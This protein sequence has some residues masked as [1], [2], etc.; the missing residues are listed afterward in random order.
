MLANQ[1]TYSEISE[2]FLEIE[3]KNQ[4]LQLE[5]QDVYAWQ[6]ARI[7]IFLQI[8]DHLIPGNTQPTIK[9]KLEKIN[10]L[11]HRFFVNCIFFNPFVDFK[12]KQVL[13]VESGRKYK[14]GNSYIDIY[15]EY[16]CQKL[17]KENI[18]YTRYENNYNLDS[19]FFKRNWTVKHLDF[20]L[21]FSKIA[22]RFVKCIW[23]EKEQEAIRGVSEELNLAFGIKLNIDQIFREE[24]KR[25]KAEFTLYYK[26]FR[27]KQAE[28]IYIINSSEKAAIIFAAK[29][30]G[31]VVKE[32]QHGLMSDKDVISNYPHTK[33]ESLKYFPDQFYIWDN[34]D[35]FFG[36]LPIKQEDIKY[37]KNQHI[38]KWVQK[39]EKVLTDHKTILVISQPYGSAEMQDFIR[40]NKEILS[41]YSIIYKMHPAE[42]EK[43]FSAFK[44]EFKNIPNIRFVNNE[45]SIYVLLKK[46]IYCLGIYSSSLFEANAFDCKVILLN[47]PGVEMSFPL[48][49]NRENKIIDI[50]QKFSDVLIY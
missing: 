7:T 16:I 19:P 2:K 43:K 29:K 21:L 22:T 33:E 40:N 47:L 34:V 35:M 50:N 45:E 17:D 9:A 42:N 38:E 37:F 23:S 39:T 36:K 32:L 27:L 12:K 10:N 48:L 18:S 30:N 11:L 15:T 1:L 14:D 46:A 8:V 49:R 25:F 5:I 26:L 13:V 31:M 28:E 41:H 6:I 3:E 4:L 44:D 20:I 24:I